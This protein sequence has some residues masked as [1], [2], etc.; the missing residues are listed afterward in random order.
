[1]RDFFIMDVMIAMRIMYV[2]SHKLNNYLFKLPVL[3][4]Q[5]QLFCS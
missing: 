1:M 2:I 3:R 5:T 4:D